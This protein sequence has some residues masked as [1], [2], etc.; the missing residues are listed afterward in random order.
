MAGQAPNRAFRPGLVWVIV[1]VIEQA[2]CKKIRIKKDFVYYKKNYT[3][4]RLTYAHIYNI[5]FT[6]ESSLKLIHRIST[7][8]IEI[9]SV[10]GSTCTLSTGEGDEECCNCIYRDASYRMRDYFAYRHVQASDGYNGSMVFLHRR[11]QIG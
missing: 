5:R 7:G 8:N 3:V 4:T 11:T 6:Y 10:T 1:S 2:H 9:Q